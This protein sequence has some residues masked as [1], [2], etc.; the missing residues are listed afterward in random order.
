MSNTKEAIELIDR[1]FNDKHDK[2]KITLSS[3]HKAKGLEND[4]VFIYRPELMPSKFA[5]T[6]VEKEQEL[7]LMYVSYTRAKKELVFVQD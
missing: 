2:N 1:I 5:V 7:N 3:I 4:K 6:E